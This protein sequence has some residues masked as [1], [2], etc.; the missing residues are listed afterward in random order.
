MFVFANGAVCTVKSRCGSGGGGNASDMLYMIMCVPSSH[1]PIVP[2]LLP[3]ILLPWT[4]G[5]IRVLQIVSFVAKKASPGHTEFTRL[6]NQ[7]GTV[8]PIT[9]PPGFVRRNIMPTECFK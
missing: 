2:R 4:I 3:V 8:G 9:Y 1:Q 5:Y 7:Y 6:A